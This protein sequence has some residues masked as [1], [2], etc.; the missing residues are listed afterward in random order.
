MLRTDYERD[1]P[2]TQMLRTDH[3]G[4]VPKIQFDRSGTWHIS[5]WLALPNRLHSARIYTFPT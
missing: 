1:V 2:K 5:H 4:D 3:E